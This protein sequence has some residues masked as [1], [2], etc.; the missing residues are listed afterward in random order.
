MAITIQ[1][2]DNAQLDAITLAEVSNSRLGGVAGGSHIQEATTRLG[3]TINTV[4]GQLA[5]LG[6]QIPPVDWIAS[7]LV[8]SNI[9]VYR[10]PAVTGDFYVAKV[11]VPFTT[12][13]SFIVTNWQPLSVATADSI[14]DTFAGNG[15]L[16]DFTLS[17]LPS[18]IVNLQVFVD[19]VFQSPSLYTLL[20]DVVTFITPPPVGISDNVVIITSK[21]VS[22]EES[23]A[24]IS[25]LAAAASAL[26]AA[27]SAIEAAN[28]AIA[29]A[30][31]ALS[32]D[33]D[34]TQTAA[35][36]IVVTGLVGSA[37]EGAVMNLGRR[38]T[39]SSSYIGGRRF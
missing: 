3:D 35:D 19:G 8:T 23:I 28:S 39:G 38:F 17:A 27:N 21:N 15:V 29:A 26:E 18:D 6:F 14:V 34:A 11:P 32:A 4:Q 24:A 31:S 9:Q 30:A 36:V 1:D 7:T 20:D 10:F 13:I 33:L 25:A 12:G 16:I 22:V 2:M 37:G 5:K